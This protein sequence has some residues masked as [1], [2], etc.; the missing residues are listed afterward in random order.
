MIK[1]ISDDPLSYTIGGEIQTSITHNHNV[2]SGSCPVPFNFLYIT[3]GEK[4]IPSQYNSN[5]IPSCTC[6]EDEI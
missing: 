3:D 4:N 6:W 5:F 2:C 1:K